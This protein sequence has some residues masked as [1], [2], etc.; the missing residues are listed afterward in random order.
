MARVMMSSLLQSS[1]S[2]VIFINNF[3]VGAGCPN[4]R[5]DV[6]LVQFMLVVLGYPTDRASA[7]TGSY[8]DPDGICGPQTVAAIKSFQHQASL[9]YAPDSLI[10]MTEDGKVSPVRRGVPGSSGAVPWS[11]AGHALT[12]VR[13]NKAYVDK[14]GPSAHADSV[15]WFLMPWEL[16]NALFME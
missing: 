8:K 16:R 4:K 7:P 6:L 15:Q 3:A 5:D 13:L 9:P 11:T 2:P 1:R 10:R 12:I 14:Y